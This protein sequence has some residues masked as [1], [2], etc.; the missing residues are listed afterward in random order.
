MAHREVKIGAPKDKNLASKDEK[1]CSD[2][3]CTHANNQQMMFVR[4]Q[5]NQKM[6]CLV[7][8]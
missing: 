6:K 8:K 2:D 1:I 3:V 4:T 7:L 5:N